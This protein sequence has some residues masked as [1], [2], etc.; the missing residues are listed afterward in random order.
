MNIL[1]TPAAEKFIRRMVRFG[2]VANGGFRL[3]V[4]PGGCSGLAAEFSIEAAPNP[5]EA[6]VEVNG[7]KLFLGAE[8]RILLDGVTIDFT[9]TRMESGL[10]FRDPKSAGSACSTQPKAP[11]LVSLTGFG[12]GK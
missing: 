6:A 9:D 8:S 1:M 4:S 11:E 3:A 10:V 12:S 7:V 2:G 5:G